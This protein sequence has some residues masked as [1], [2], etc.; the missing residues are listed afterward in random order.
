[1]LAESGTQ[2]CNGGTCLVLEV[3]LVSGLHLGQVQSLTVAVLL[4]S[5]KIQRHVER[6]RALPW[7]QDVDRGFFER[8]SDWFSSWHDGS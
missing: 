2:L 5:G 6:F 8:M 1:M 7:L 3:A 4:P